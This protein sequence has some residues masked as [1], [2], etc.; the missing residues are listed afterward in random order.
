MSQYMSMGM[1][2]KRKAYVLGVDRYD[3]QI[4]CVKCRKKVIHDKKKNCFRHGGVNIEC[5]A[6]VEKQAY[7]LWIKRLYQSN[8]LKLYRRCKHCDFRYEEKL[9]VTVPGDVC[10]QH[11]KVSINHGG[12]ST[13]YK[14][15]FAI[16]NANT[17]PSLRFGIQYRENHTTQ[18][19]FLQWVLPMVHYVAKC[20]PLWVDKYP[21]EI[22]STTPYVCV[23]CVN[24]QC[25]C[26]NVI[27]GNLCSRCK[28]PLCQKCDT[29]G[30]CQFPCAYRMTVALRSLTVSNGLKNWRN[31]SIR[32]IKIR[33][34]ALT[35]WIRRFRATRV[36]ALKAH[37]DNKWQ[38]RYEKYIGTVRKLALR[39]YDRIKYSRCETCK[40][41]IGREHYDCKCVSRTPL[42]SQC[43]Q[44]LPRLKGYCYCCG[45]PT[46]DTWKT[47]CTACYYARRAQRTKCMGCGKWQD[48]TTKLRKNVVVCDKCLVYCDR[49]H[50]TYMKNGTKSVCIKCGIRIGKGHRIFEYFNEELMV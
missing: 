48:H 19:L 21:M 31:R 28:K 35:R 30:E 34:R 6:K 33:Q 49:G 1:T 17:T 40:E 23:Y 39:W 43:K 8:T 37:P 29:R 13:E 20:R 44:C 42:P 45:V 9:P 24:K 26:G 47:H 25:R 15:D 22:K 10:K 27:T 46:T 32:C 36:I 2:R 14:I 41:K 3:D 50:G 5:V 11:Y 38:K 16:V 7:A 18:D 4:A 12:E